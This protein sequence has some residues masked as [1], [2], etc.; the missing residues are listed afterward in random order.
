MN[1]K[2]EVLVR[3]T[4]AG[5]ASRSRRASMNRGW[6][7]ITPSPSRLTGRKTNGCPA[8]AGGSISGG[9]VPGLAGRIMTLSLPMR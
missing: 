3:E 9:F 1:K 6:T 4:D 2:G 5:N 8:G 7:A